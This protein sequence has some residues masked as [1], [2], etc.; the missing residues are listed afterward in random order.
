[1]AVMMS[2]AESA[3]EKRLLMRRRYQKGTL[4]LRGKREP[5]W[6][7][8]WLDDEVR[9]DGT[10]HRRHKSAVLGLASE[11]SKREARRELD[12]ILAP[13]NAGL[14]SPRH[15]ITFSE[16]AERWKQDV[17]VHHKASGQ[18]S[19]RA[20]I[21][22]W[23]VPAFGDCSI[24][25]IDTQTIQRS[26]TVWSKKAAPKT[27]RNILATMRIIWKTARA[28]GYV[29]H[30]PFAA[31]MLPR[32]GLVRKPTLT[33][34]QTREIIQLADEPYKTLFW[35]VAETGMRGGEV[36]GLFVEDVDLAGEFIH[37]RRSAW[38][39]QLQ[40]PKTE[41]AVR[42]FPI[43]PVLAL[44]LKTFI[45]DRTGLLFA[46][47]TG[48]PLDNYNIVAWAL[49]PLLTEIG[50]ENTKQM[51]LHAFRHCN[52]SALDSLGAPMRIRMDRLGHAQQET[53]MGYSH[54]NLGDHRRI[55]AELGQV[56]RP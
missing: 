26:V 22:K 9:S 36:C 27:V 1:M 46:T 13:I 5:V 28:W 48:K 18:T 32:R 14:R 29:E 43:S 17:M 25:D 8:R 47:R 3:V 42:S 41:N 45:G 2:G 4:L 39:A 24:C 52:A 11:L 31:L 35:I 53:T 50:I 20:H 37:V 23:L 30:D 15:V 54:S 44:H 51:G 12:K 6:I 21:A 55:A 33:P 40:T 7:G 16:F 10:I 34:E 49:K 19:E 56:F 38:R